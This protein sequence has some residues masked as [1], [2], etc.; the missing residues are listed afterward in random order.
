[1]IHLRSVHKRKT[2]PTVQDTFPFRLPVIQ[3]LS[4]I[5]FSTEVTFLV[6]ENGS[7]KSTILEAIAYA[8]GSTTV[9]SESVESDKTLSPIRAFAR[10][11]KLTWTKKTRTGLFLRS[12]D[13]FG[14]VKRISAIR[15]GLQKDLEAVD[16]EYVNRSA[17]ARSLA[18]MPYLREIREI[19]RYYDGDLD[20]HSHG[21]SY[22]TLFKSRFVPNGL[23]LLDEPEAPLSP[24]RQIIFLSMLKMMVKQNAQFIIAT[25]SPIILA[26]PGA[27]ILSFDGGKIE[28][29][30]YA[31]LD[32]VVVTKTFLNDPAHYLKPLFEE[33]E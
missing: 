9:G 21:E 10:T 13:F 29:V 31:N 19:E 4:E 8:A 32:H 12:E 22:F 23:Y 3:S 17:T 2:D 18:R 1:M 15:D 25:H 7:G 33:L 30:D 24:L 14:F 6:G 11:L 28:K 16:E 20:A 5:T 27:T 26:Y